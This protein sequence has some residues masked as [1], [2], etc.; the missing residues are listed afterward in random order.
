MIRT[1]ALTDE[2]TVFPMVSPTTDRYGNAVEERAAGVTIP[3]RVEPLRSPRGDIELKG[4]RD[5]FVSEYT[6]YTQ[7]CAA[8][9]G[10]AEVEWNGDLYEVQGRP[11]PFSH[12]LGGQSHVETYLRRIEG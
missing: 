2:I 1:A 4:G 5:T 7:P 9:T 10:T 12:L 6:A 11:K 8:L 3:A